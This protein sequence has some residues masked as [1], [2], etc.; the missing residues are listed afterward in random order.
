MHMIFSFF[1]A[2]G[3]KRRRRSVAMALWLLRLLRDAESDEMWRYSDLLDTIDADVS[4]RVFV[5]VE[6]D[7][8]NSESALGYIESAIEDLEFAY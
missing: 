8:L 4:R 6:D 5:A 1:L 3:S 2:S 7:Y